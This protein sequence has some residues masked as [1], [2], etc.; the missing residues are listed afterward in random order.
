MRKVTLEAPMSVSD[1][2]EDMIVDSTPNI[3]NRFRGIR[4]NTEEYCVMLLLKET[5]L[6]F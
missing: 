4:E 1:S 2:Q 6:D 5:E 3:I